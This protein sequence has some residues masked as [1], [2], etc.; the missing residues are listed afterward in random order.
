MDGHIGVCAFAREAFLGA[1]QL[2]EAQGFEVVHGIVDSLWLKKPDASL[3]EY[4]RLCEKIS[5]QNRG[6]YKF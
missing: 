4:Q 6:A 3:E 1:A 5:G 2:A